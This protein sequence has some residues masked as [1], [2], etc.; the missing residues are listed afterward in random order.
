MENLIILVQ[1]SLF[2]PY[3]SYALI[4]KVLNPTLA[5]YYSNEPQ[6]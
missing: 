6:A 1:T 3:N 5:I 2:N 4:E